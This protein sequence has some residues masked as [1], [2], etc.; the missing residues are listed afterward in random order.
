M[1]PAWKPLR[2][3]A[4][5]G[6]WRYHRGHDLKPT[7]RSRLATGPVGRPVVPSGI[8]PEIDVRGAGDPVLVGSRVL[9]PLPGDAGQDGPRLR[10]PDQRLHRQQSDPDG[11]VRQ[12]RRKGRDRP[13]ALPDRRT[14]GPLWRGDGR[15]RAG[16]NER[17][18]RLARRRP[19][20]APALRL[21]PPI[22]L[23]QQLLH[24]Y[25]RPRLGTDVHQDHCLCA[26]PDVGL[27]ERERVVQAAG[28][29]AG[30]RFQ[31]VG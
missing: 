14:R 12:G 25:P 15:D 5:C 26:V 1:A 11:E 6:C 24:L 22:D 10:Q 21:P 29:P 31:G 3:F 13:Q 18:A 8:R 16:E 23:P 30:R 19:G 4:P 27:S 28:R 7:R 2:G 9:D 17:V 20:R